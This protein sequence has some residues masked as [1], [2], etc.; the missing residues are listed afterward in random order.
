M[1]AH[2]NFLWRKNKQI[3]SHS[4]FG[5]GKNVCGHTEWIRSGGH[6]YHLLLANRLIKNRIIIPAITHA[7]IIAHAGTG[8]VAL[9]PDDENK[10][11]NGELLFIAEAFSFISDFSA[12]KKHLNIP[13]GGSVQKRFSTPH[14]SQAN[15]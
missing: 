11:S 8:L 15:P 5:A 14:F 1:S 2:K 4:A 6:C 10:K 13:S 7:N 9:S 12:H 3:V